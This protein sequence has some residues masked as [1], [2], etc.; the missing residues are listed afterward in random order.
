M[1]PQKLKLVSHV[2]TEE[3]TGV[4]L[5]KVKACQGLPE[6]GQAESIIE[7]LGGESSCRPHAYGTVRE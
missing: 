3:E 6:P 4:M 1:K 7:A 5:L 2:G